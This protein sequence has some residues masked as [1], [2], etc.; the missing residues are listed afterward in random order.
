[1]KLALVYLSTGMFHGQP[2]GLLCLTSWIKKYVPQCEVRIVDSNWENPE[3]VLTKEHFDYIGISAMTGQFDRAKRL[4]KLL[5]SSGC[6]PLLIGGVHVST[7]QSSTNDFDV[8]L[9]G[10]GEKQLVDFLTG[11]IPKPEPVSLIDYPDL[12]YRL[13]N[14]SYFKPRLCRVWQECIVEAIL[15]TSRGCPYHCQFCSTT[16]FWNGYRAHESE[17]VVRQVE[18]LADLGVTHLQV[19]DD[20]FLCNKNRFKRIVELWRAKGLHRKIKV[21]GCNSRANLFD[22]ETIELS[23]S[24]NVKTIQFGFES[25]SDRILKQIKVTGASNEL[26]R[27]VLKLSNGTGIKITASMMM[28]MPGE[29]FLDMMKT[30]YFIL[31]STFKG[32]DDIWLYLATP[33]PSTLWWSIA[34]ERGNVSNE[35]DFAI[36]KLRDKL[37]IN[38][39]LVDIPKWQFWLCWWLAFVALLP[40]KAR[41][42]F[43]LGIGYFRFLL[44]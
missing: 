29:T 6:P 22:I 23:K 7:C 39:L 32:I 14:P 37:P 10:E 25:G 3:A 35:M 30:V 9:R 12:D 4:S 33:Y 24:I 28:G 2:F 17:W 44:R 43:K 16:V 15:I 27:K 38:S 1:M 26:N 13:L 40:L 20:L 34:L 42:L 41:K 11:Q 31:W 5:R 36:L 21:V 18:H 19:S 8:V